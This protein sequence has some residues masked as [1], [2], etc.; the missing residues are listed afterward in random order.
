MF[1]TAEALSFA[2]VKYKDPDASSKAVLGEVGPREV[3][4]RQWLKLTWEIERALL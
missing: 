3:D 4:F 2:F 1:P